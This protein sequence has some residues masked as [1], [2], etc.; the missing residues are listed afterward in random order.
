[1]QVTVVDQIEDQPVRG[2]VVANYLRSITPSYWHLRSS[3]H[4]IESGVNYTIG[5]ATYLVPWL[6][7]AATQLGLAHNRVP[8]IVHDTMCQ[9]PDTMRLLSHT[10]SGVST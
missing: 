10:W 8:V 5:M 9:T 6:L 3:P 7:S 1:M 4:L 2:A